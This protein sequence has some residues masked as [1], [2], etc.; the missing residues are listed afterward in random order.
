MQR[1]VFNMLCI[2]VLLLVISHAEGGTV[3][4]PG[5]PGT[6]T[7]NVASMKE[8]RFRKIVQQQYDYSCGSATLAT[9]LTYHYEDPVTEQD[10]FK[11]MFENGDQEKIRKEGFSMLDMKKYLEAREYKADGFR[12]SLD[13]LR[14][15]GVPA[16]VLVNTRGYKHFVVIKGVTDNRVLLG[17]PALGTRSLP[18]AEFE[19]MWNGLIFIVRNKK[20]IA[21]NHFND[22]KEWGARGK[23]PLGLAL[24]SSELAHM[25]LNIPLLGSY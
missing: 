18:R 2:S 3:I 23:A 17:D 10:V 16:I 5:S 25:T 13:K 12:V 11:A 9:L 19:Q 20:N 14:D 15:I 6:F 24:S 8:L 21:Q 7:V 4:V 22:D 1:P